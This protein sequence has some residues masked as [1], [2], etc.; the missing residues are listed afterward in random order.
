MIRFGIALLMGVLLGAA[1]SVAQEGRV[2]YEETIKIQ[3]Q[4]PPEALAMGVQIPDARTLHHE[5]FFN[6]SASL[7]KNAPRE[8]AEQEIA[9]HGDGPQ[10]RMRMRQPD[11][12]VFTDFEEET[13][14]EKRNFLNRTFLI[15]GDMP[16]RPWQIT[17]EQSEFLGYLC[18]KAVLKQ[19]TTTVE[20]WFTP[21]IPIPAGPGRWS[22]LPGLVLLVNIDDGRHTFVAKDVLLEP[23]EANLV[24]APDKGRVVT[25][26]EFEALV[27]E[28]MKEMGMQRGPGAGMMRVIV[29]DH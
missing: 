23:L 29:R 4:L 15:T 8:E 7:L 1:S 17:T 20:A 5:L 10:F 22:G 18:Q 26:D 9:S 2:Q 28:R 16:S 14:I 12:E 3:L 27:E 24:V 11:D 13:V 25:R 6:E 21:E 19:D